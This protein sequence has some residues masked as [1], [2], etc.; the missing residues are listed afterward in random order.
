[1]REW[2]VRDDRKNRFFKQETYDSWIEY[3]LLNGTEIGVGKYKI[4][5][6]EGDKVYL[7]QIKGGS[8]YLKIDNG[9]V[10]ESNFKFAFTKVIHNGNWYS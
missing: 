5:K 1:M 6:R 9:M 7:K 2:V 10:M 8:R 3:I 4:Y